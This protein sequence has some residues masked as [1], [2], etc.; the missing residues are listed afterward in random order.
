MML[1]V[2]NTLAALLLFTLIGFSQKELQ[3]KSGLHTIVIDAGHGGKD[4]GTGNGSTKEKNVALKVALKL[5]K[6]IEEGIPDVKVIFTRKTDIFIPLHERA[7]IANRNKAD[8]FICVH[9]NA[10]PYS[11]KIKGSETYVMGL[12]KTEENL[13]LAKR[14]NEVILLEDNYKK[15]YR[16]FDLNSPMAHIIMAN[17]QSAYMKESLKLATKVEQNIKK[18]GH[19]SRGVKQA[20]FQVLW[21]TSMPSIYIET[22]YLTNSEDEATLTSEKGQ[23][24]LAEAVF[25]ALK[26]YKAEN[27]K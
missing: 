7:A 27:E 8:L 2:L 19:N 20:G 10:N 3:S 17:Y 21:Q 1:K 13:E 24:K 5:G 9:V 25:K 22:G 6:K 11:S 16:G 15:N 18:T 12:H 14:E 26:S 23:D 4:P